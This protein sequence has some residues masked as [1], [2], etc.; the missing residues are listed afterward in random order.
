MTYFYLYIN[1][2]VI[3]EKCE[4]CGKEYKTKQ[5]LNSHIGWHNNPNRKSNL[6][7]YNEDVLN[8]LVKNGGENQFTKAKRLGLN[9]EMSDNTKKKISDSTRIRM[10]EYWKDDKN[11]EK[12]SIAMKNAVL[13]NPDSYSHS[14]VSGR[15]KSFDFLDS[16]NN[17]IKMKGK[18]ELKFAVFLNDKNIKWTNVI[19]PFPYFWNDSWHLYFP[20]FYLPDFNVYVEIKGYERERDIQKWCQ[21]KEKLYK[22]KKY[23][24][25]NL[26]RWYLNIFEK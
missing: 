14:N 20:D 19:K 24:I 18:W 15:V 3:M 10:V 5:G 16:F 8:G 23:E 26:D 6:L 17:K 1:K 2:K 22:I 25:S 4:I 12:Q 11:K 13:N 9:I 21:F 7:K